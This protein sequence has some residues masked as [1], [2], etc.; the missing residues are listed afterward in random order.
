MAGIINAI[1]ASVS[2]RLQ[3]SLAATRLVVLLETILLL[4]LSASRFI[5]SS[6]TFIRNKAGY[7]RGNVGRA[8]RNVKIH[9][10]ASWN[11]ASTS[12]SRSMLS[13]DNRY[14]IIIINFM[15]AV[16]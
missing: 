10:V 8:A 13:H 16:G 6:P 14:T 9:K 5:P 15:V 1:V 12:P 3:F 7:R 11:E 2:G 4:S